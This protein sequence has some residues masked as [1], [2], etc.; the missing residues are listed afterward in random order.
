[1]STWCSQQDRPVWPPFTGTGP[2]CSG[3][4]SVL[5]LSRMPVVAVTTVVPCLGEAASDQAQ[6]G[7]TPGVV[8]VAGQSPVAVTVDHARRVDQP[9]FPAD[10]LVQL[11]LRGPRAAPPQ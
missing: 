2:D 4:P 11:P 6:A 1:M 3:R 10:P 5:G 7:V 8:D 9:S